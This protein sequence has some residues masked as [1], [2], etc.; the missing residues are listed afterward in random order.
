MDDLETIDYNND[1]N[2]DDLETVD[3][4][5]DRRPNELDNKIENIDLKNTSKIL[6][7]KRQLKK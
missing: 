6:Q 5:N 4:N 1:V 7:Y 2:F 3:F